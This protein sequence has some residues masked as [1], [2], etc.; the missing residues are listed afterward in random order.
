MSLLRDR[1]AWLQGEPFGCLQPPAATGSPWRLVLLGPPGA[2]KGT[3]SEMLATV[4]GA[5]PLS[6]ADIF[7]AACERSHAP[8]SAMAAA[9]EAMNYGELVPDD[10]VLGIIRDRRACLRCRGGF[11][12]DGFPRTLPQAVTLDG[13]L[14]AEH[15]PLDAVICYDLPLHLLVERMAGRRVCP[16]C[17]ALFHVTARPP[18]REGICDYCGDRLRQRTDDEPAAARKRLEVYAGATAQVVNYY[19]SRRPVVPIDARGSP[20]RILLR[21]LDALA[22]RGFSVPAT[23]A[24]TGPATPASSGHSTES[25][26]T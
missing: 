10:V 6:T 5:C 11:L 26:E 4:L 23:T 19:A 18:R 24:R 3:Q 25:R 17:H 1:T 9:E 22:A 2:G 20:E 16:R 7:R 14:A 13:L 21:T 8:G 15:L 12:L